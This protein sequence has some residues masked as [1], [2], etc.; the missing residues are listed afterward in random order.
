MPTTLARM[1]H[2]YAR[3]G[4]T[5]LFAAV[6]ISSGSVIDAAVPRDLDLRLLLDNHATHKTPT[7]TRWRIRHPRFHP[8]STPTSSSWLNLVERW[9]AELTARTLR[10]SAHCVATVL[11]A[12]VRRWIN[13]WNTDP[14]PF[15]WTT[16]TDQILDTL[17]AYCGRIND[18][19]H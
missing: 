9:F 13:E 2:D 19:R 7:V 6:D 12:G 15:V 10:R 18:S 11:E 17:T 16:T 1:T 5:S 4:T 14:R 3:H 8:H